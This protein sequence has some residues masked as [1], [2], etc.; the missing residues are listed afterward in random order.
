MYKHK[1]NVPKGI[2]FLSDWKEF[3]LFGFPYIINKQLTGCGF[4]QWCLTEEENIILCSPRRILLE[5]KYDAYLESFT[6]SLP[7]R[8]YYAKND[9]EKLV[10]VEKDLTAIGKPLP[11][12][13][14]RARLRKED[15][16]EKKRQE[17]A[18]LHALEFKE[19]VK[20]F[21]NTCCNTT[22]SYRAC[23]ILVT[24]DS[25]RKVKE[26][27]L[28]LGVYQSFHVVIDEF[29][30]IFTDSRFKSSTEIGF[31]TDLGDTKKCCFVSATPM[32]DKYLNELDE[33]R[34]L[35][36]LDLDWGTSDPGRI[37]KPRIIASPQTR[38]ITKVK[39][40][41]E[42]YRGQRPWMNYDNQVVT[43]KDPTTGEI[44]SVE[45]KEAIFYINSV[46]NICDIIRICE[47]KQE[48]CNVLCANTSDNAERVRKAF[49]VKPS[50][51]EG[52]GRVPKKSEMGSNKMFT[53]CT[54]TVY[55][56]ADFW[57]TNARSYV[58]SDANINCLSVDITLDLPQILGRQRN[59][60][61][62]WKNELNVYYKTIL[63]PLKISAVDFEEYVN[64][65][66]QETMALLRAFGYADKA[67]D[68]EATMALSKQYETTAKDRN[69]RDNYVAVN[70]HVGKQPEPVLNN[71][72]MLSE[73]RAFEIQQCDFADRCTVRNTI[74]H[75]FS[76]TE[77]KALAEFLGDYFKESQFPGKIK[78][79]CEFTDR[80]DITDDLKDEMLRRID[81]HVS[82]YI[83]VLGTGR[84][85]ANSYSSGKLSK[86]LSKVINNQGIDVSRE[87]LEAFRCGERYDNKYIKERLSQIY[88]D[89]GMKKLPKA[90]DLEKYL[91]TRQTTFLRDGI[92]LNG[93]LI[94]SQ[95]SQGK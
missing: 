2:R 7:Y 85:K 63:D 11:P 74:S 27:L 57:S 32:I 15:E 41:V 3:R 66:R 34:N 71:L 55:L 81:P 50:L 76:I 23:K 49:K 4:T 10:N 24:Y 89:K 56:G 43:V 21:Y 79:A 36:Y 33:F 77:D 20:D 38:V 93:R 61:N 8:M 12:S 5:N 35:P 68:S 30:S 17:G 9:Y 44:K 28:E 73:I 53:F 80:P 37:V 87:V 91:E 54:R 72:V 42:K 1:I 47:L 59:D 67:Q 52:I 22:A 6:E 78:A 31:M 45:S 25:F 64:V 90:T 29:Q 51:F 19:G 18:K 14:I 26:A 92:R 39:E 69:Y 95:R 65:K 60:D 40:I 13:I 82:N 83:R 46:K 94:V 70:P 48:E 58:F 62:P 86:E 16:E 88:K 75:V 84:I